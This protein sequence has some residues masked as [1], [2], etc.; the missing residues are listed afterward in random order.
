MSADAEL[1]LA[2]TLKARDDQ[3]RHIAAAQREL[4]G[5]RAI[6]AS[7]DDQ[8][9]RA[10]RRVA[11]LTGTSTTDLGP[12]RTVVQRTVDLELHAAHHADA[13]CTDPRTPHAYSGD[14]RGVE[15]W[16]GQLLGAVCGFQAPDGYDLDGVHV[17]PWC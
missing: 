5:R 13:A 12:S 8:V 17:A 9:A 10:R 1:E 2:Y 15:C 16:A 11:A 6:L 7:L 3:H 4:A 14:P